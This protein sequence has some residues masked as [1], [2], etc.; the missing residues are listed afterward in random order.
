MAGGEH[1]PQTEPLGHPRDP[2]QDALDYR[3]DVY[4]QVEGP[5]DAPENVVRAALAYQC[6][7]C[8]V[9]VFIER[10][11]H[12][13]VVEPGWSIMIA[14]DERCPYLARIEA[15]SDVL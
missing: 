11:E 5:K 12:G 9:N 6:P 3:P 8:N 14:H 15:E 1:D 13:W 4:G 7:D 10:G 2:R